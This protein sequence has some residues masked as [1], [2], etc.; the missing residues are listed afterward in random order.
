MEHLNLLP[1]SQYGG[2]K[3]HTATDA[4]HSLVSFAKDAWRRKQEVVVLFLDV[5]G[6]FPNVAIPVLVH[7]MKKMGFHTRYTDWIVNKTTDRE[8]VLVFDN[9]VSPPFTVTHG[10]DQGCNLLPFL[11]NCYSASQMKAVRNKKDELGNT[12]TDDSVCAAKANTLQEAA[13]AILE[14]FKR[15]E[16]LEEWGK[17]HFSLY[18]LVK[19]GGLA[20]TRKKIVD[21]A[22]P[23]K[24]IRQPP[25]TIMLDDQ[26][27]ITTSSTQKY[28]GVIIDS[29]LRFKEH[30]AY[31]I[32]KGTK[33]AKQARCLT[34]VAK[35]VNGVLTRRMYYGATVASMLYAVDVW[36]APSFKIRRRGSDLNG[37]SSTVKKLESIQRV[38]AIQATGSLCMAPSD[39]LFAHA[40]MLSMRHLVKTHCH[41]A[42]IWLAFLNSHHP[43]HY[44]VWR[45]A[46]RYPKRHT[47]PLHDI[48]Y[49]SKIGPSSM[50]MVNPHPRH[51]SW[52]PPIKA[53]IV[54][55]IE[56]ACRAERECEADIKIYSDG[57]GHK[58]NI[59]A[60]AIMK[61]GFRTPKT[62]RFHLGSLTKH[63]V[64]EGECVGQLLGLKLLQSS[65]IDLNGRE[66]SLGVDNQ[67]AIA[68]LN[69]RVSNS[70]T[71]ITDEIYKT[72]YKLTTKFP[73]AKF[74]VRW[75]P[76]HVGIAGNEE[77]D[78]EAKKAASGLCF[79]TNCNFGILK[80]PLPISRSAHR[81]VL[82]DEVLLLYREEFQH[83]ARICRSTRYDPTMP[84]NRYRKLIESLPR[85]HTSILTQLRTNHIPLRAYLHKIKVEDSP[86][87]P[88]C[89]DAPET[90]THFL[91]FCP[92]YATQRR[93]LRSTLR[94]GQNLDLA[95]LGDK[96]SLSN[97]L[98]FVRK[99][100]RF[101][102]FFGDAPAVVRA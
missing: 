96:A 45:E 97:L 18:D 40:D 36:C 94:L 63:T 59:G 24:R 66:I 26:H 98:R 25:V 81:Q 79:N 27:S 70:A 15:P 68:R 56:E 77:V 16:G 53:N 7:D 90:V 65:G 95:L 41:R 34:K 37:M 11:Y 89:E 73:Q 47:S 67:A 74:E 99:S 29:E 49:L 38:A 32:G 85:L 83:S 91:M 19:S 50:E 102:E 80:R 52:K 23:R 42:A 51:P 21:P 55:S 69:M 86:V 62:A 46:G 72:V 13:E 39:L 92:R 71:Y 30:A 6:A 84:S 14:L 8:M 20:V 101:E 58:G 57:S 100:K 35:G 4:I 76:G 1:H 2:H 48:L 93:E 22:N 88:H 78:I 44:V 60:A 9:Y 33:W 54:S 28:L 87:C 5:K 10:L 43:L 3:G 75:T 31:A 17:S 64:F 82:K 12:Y 61:F